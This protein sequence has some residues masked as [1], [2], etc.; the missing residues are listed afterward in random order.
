M[1]LT[2]AAGTTHDDPQVLRRLHAVANAPIF[3]YYDNN[4][5]DGI[6]GGPLISVQARSQIA[7]EVA[8]RMLR[9]E[10]SRDLKVQSV[11]FAAP[12]FDWREMQRWGISANSLPLGSEIYFRSPSAW[13]QYR[14]QILAIVAALLAQ[15]ALIGWLFYEIGRRRRAEIQSRH[16]IAEL[17]YMDRRA[18]AGQL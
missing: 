16:S 3:S 10:K 18:A 11:G 15:A 14:Q 2:D 17:T 1:L 9:G 6:V 4:F 5:G 12:K 7:A 8:L 13:E